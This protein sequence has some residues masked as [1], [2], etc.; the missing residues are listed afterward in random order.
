MV[1]RADYASWLRKQSGANPSL[2]PD[3]PCWT[4]IYREIGPFRARFDRLDP[5][6]PRDSA[7]LDPNSLSSWAGISQAASS[8]PPWADQRATFFD[9]GN[10]LSAGISALGA[11]SREGKTPLL[12]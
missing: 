4:G 9:H 1:N 8:E 5:P 3:F 6:I 7:G 10:G 2:E 12:S 11:A